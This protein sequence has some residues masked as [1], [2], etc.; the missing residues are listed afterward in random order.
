MRSKAMS[1]AAIE[2]RVRVLVEALEQALVCPIHTERSYG[3]DKQSVLH[4]VEI[5]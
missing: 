1:V 5:E 3:S 2:R 4:I